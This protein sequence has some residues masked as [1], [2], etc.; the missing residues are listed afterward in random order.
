MDS[1]LGATLTLGAFG[2]LWGII[3]LYFANRER[4]ANRAKRAAM[5]GTPSSA[6]N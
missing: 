4:K 2:L 6:P 1:L 3:G 5:A